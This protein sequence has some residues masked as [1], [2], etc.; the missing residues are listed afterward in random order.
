MV[1][2][3]GT[4]ED[5]KGLLKSAIRSD[6]PV[7]FIEHATLTRCAEKFPMANIPSRSASRKSSAPGSDVTIV[8]YSKMLDFSMKAAEQ[9]VKGWH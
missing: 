9:L 7:L 2:A 3:P 1:V 6:D 4:P 5:A 8:T